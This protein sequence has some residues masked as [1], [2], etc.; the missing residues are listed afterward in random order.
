LARSWRS[1][2][3][4]ARASTHLTFT[5]SPW[6]HLSLDSLRANCPPSNIHATCLSDNRHDATFTMTP[7]L[8]NPHSWTSTPSQRPFNASYGLTQSQELGGDFSRLSSSA[9][10]SCAMSVVLARQREYPWSPRYP[11]PTRNEPG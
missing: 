2:K 11:I 10:V 3:L 5:T 6:Q 8:T 7:R 4:D 9:I 1:A